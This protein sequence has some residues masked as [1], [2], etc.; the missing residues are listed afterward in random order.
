MDTQCRFC[1]SPKVWLYYR[2]ESMAVTGDSR[3]VPYPIEVCYCSDCCTLYK[4]RSQRDDEYIDDI[5]ESR[6]IYG[7]G[8]IPEQRVAY[9]KI[10]GGI[11]KSKHQLQYIADRA[12]LGKFGSILDFGCSCG[13][14]LKTFNAVYPQW[15]LV[16]FDVAHTYADII[17]G[18]SGASSFI[19]KDLDK[20]DD[21]FDLIT[22]S[23]VMEHMG[24][25]A[26]SIQFAESRL[27]PDGL[28]YLQVINACENL[29][30][31]LIFD[32]Y[33]SYTPWSILHLLHGLG[34]EIVDMDQ[35]W[36]HKEISILARKAGKASGERFEAFCRT[37]DKAETSV[38]IQD[39]SRLLKET[40]ANLAL[41]RVQGQKT[42]ILGTTFAATWAGALLGESLEFYVDENPEKKHKNHLGVRIIEPAETK[43]GDTVLV[44]LPPKIALPIARRLEAVCEARFLVP[45][46]VEVTY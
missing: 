15:K 37:M 23:H 4:V 34:L 43:A 45:P 11:E 20:I 21:T 25:P 9:D 17:T 16:G 12:S 35:S 1:R 46:F 26:L 18:I 7:V 29:F 14:F 36:I 27:K 40:E 2:S 13:V 24:D 39:N 41:A 28:L 8:N 42:G 31:P 5:N 22:M 3:I 6:R 33:Q 38:R 44:M 10:A 30:S 32:H 19:C